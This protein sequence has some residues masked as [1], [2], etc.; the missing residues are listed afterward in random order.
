MRNDFSLRECVRMGV[1]QREVQTKQLDWSR[2]ACS[3][4]T[5]AAVDFV[6]KLLS[7]NQALRLS[8]QQGQPKCREQ[9]CTLCSQPR[10]RI[11]CSSL[12][13]PCLHARYDVFYLRVS[14][15]WGVAALEHP[16][17]SQ[18]TEDKALSIIGKEKLELAR[19]SLSM[20]WL[21]SL[22]QSSREKTARVR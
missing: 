4:L 9:F 16:W 21:M 10:E 19:Y 20:C 1:C 5:E 3:F 18:A 13:A 7:R 14:S 12:P 2:A 17:I 8:A 22:L 6:S 11:C 15:G